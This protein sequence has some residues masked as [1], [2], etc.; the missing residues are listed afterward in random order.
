MGL[1]LWN[2]A[3]DLRSAFEDVK[4]RTPDCFPCLLVRVARYRGSL[5]GVE[6]AQ[7]VESKD[8]IRVR[9]SEEHRIDACNAVGQHLLSK[10]DRGVDEDAGM[11]GD[12]D[13]NGR[14]QSAIARVGRTA[15]GAGA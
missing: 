3:A 5:Q 7:I 15:G 8:V 4:E 1:E 9:V 11:S 10:I 13:V 2:A 12:I 14:A 6:G